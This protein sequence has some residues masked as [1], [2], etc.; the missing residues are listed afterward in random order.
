MH[1]N[2]K[3]VQRRAPVVLALIT[4]HI[5]HHPIQHFRNILQWLK[6]NGTQGNV[7]PPP[8]IYGSKRSPISDCYNSIEKG[9]QPLSGAQT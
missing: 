5:M 6:Y 4:R 1:C 8:P 9:I 2:L 3:T 7:V